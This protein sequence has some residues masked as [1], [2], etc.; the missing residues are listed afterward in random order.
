MIRR[1][2][3]S[4]L[5]ALAMAGCGGGTDVADTT[6]VS[7]ST[8]PPTLPTTTPSTTT[9]S[10]TTTTTSTTTTSATTTSTTTTTTTSTAASVPIPAG[11]SV[12]WI[13]G[14]EAVLRDVSLPAAAALLTP[15]L[16][17]VPATYTPFT[18]IDPSPQETAGFAQQAVAEGANA[19]IVTVNPQWIDERECAG[20]EPP[21]SRF[22]CLLAP[23]DAVGATAIALL[24][25]ELIALNVP[26][27]LVMQPVSSDAASSPELAP[28]IA[29]AR[30]KLTGLVPD[31]PMLEIADVEFTAGV[32]EFAEGIG[33]YDMVHPTSAGAG[34][35]AAE[36]TSQLDQLLLTLL[37]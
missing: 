26:T 16:T 31:S 21:H 30:A 37:G 8:L 24:L 5:V 4:I 12:G 17:G 9:T 35:L 14:S 20:V 6:R 33:F 27:L 23:G 22:A 29:D 11:W 34:P 32:P 2:A 13:G 7:V 10:T 28:L 3:G 25:D 36:L 19:L 1:A 18:K 15:S